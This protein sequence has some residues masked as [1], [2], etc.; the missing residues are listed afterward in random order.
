MAPRRAG[1]RGSDLPLEAVARVAQD[2]QAR[3]AD[4][5]RRIRSFAGAA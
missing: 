2:A 1:R 5:W 4:A 3:G